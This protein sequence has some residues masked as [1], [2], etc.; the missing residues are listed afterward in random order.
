M[1]IL[2]VGVDKRDDL[3]RQQQNE[4]KLGRE[5]GQR[6][7]TMMVLHLSEDHT[8]VTV[9]SLPRD[10]WLDDP[11]QGPAQDQRGLPARRREAHRA[12]R[13]DATG[14]TVDHYIEVNVLGFI[15]VVDSLGGV[16]SA[17]P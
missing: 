17:P 5:V 1:N 14:L 12:D 4:L 11:R 10:T 15:N 2:V 6:T 13:A 8:K 9:V 7:D 3:T 16:R